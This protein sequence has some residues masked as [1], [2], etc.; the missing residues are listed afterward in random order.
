[1]ARMPIDFNQQVIEEFR[2][3]RGLV[4]GPF[5]GGRLLLLT[6]TGARTGTP[7]TTPLGY[8]PDGL[9]KI[10]IASAGGAPR[11]PTWYRNLRANPRVTVEDGIFTYR[12]TAVI[13]DGEERDTFFARAVELDPGWA[14]YQERAGRV[15]PV[16]ALE[17]AGGGGPAVGVPPGEFL[18]QVHD[19]FRRE[20]R[21]IRAELSRSGPRLGAQLRINCLTACQGLAHHHGIEDGQVFPALAERHPELDETLAALRAEHERVKRLLDELSELISAD[22]V[23]PEALLAGVDRLVAELEAH[24]DHEEERLVPILN[25]FPA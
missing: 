12:A 23:A 7:H 19:A 2:A 14:A 13:L 17:R 22:A 5:E 20:L 9:R 24:L 25:A 8:L 21:L 1:M 3:N 16:I 18:R 10:V 6:T 11:H 15:L 4:G